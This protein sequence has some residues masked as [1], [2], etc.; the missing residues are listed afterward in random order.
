MP[1]GSP[2]GDHR[3]KKIAGGGRI[4]KTTGEMLLVEFA[5]VMDAI[6]TQLPPL[7]AL[8][9]NYRGYVNEALGDKKAAIN[10]FERALTIDPSLA[11][12]RDGLRR[13]AAKSHVAEGNN[14]LIAKGR[15]IA[16]KDCSW[17]HTVGLI[18][19]SPNSGAPP[20]RDNHR[21]YPILSLRASMSRAIVKPH[22]AMPKRQLSAAE[23]DQLIANISSL[24]PTR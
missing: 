16:T 11:G 2:R 24:R 21:R 1:E 22:D 13:L 14:L 19:S 17:C 10:D 3:P 8:A 4:V 15:E 5:S 12:A 9:S 18:G 20:L 23:I 7:Y 6:A